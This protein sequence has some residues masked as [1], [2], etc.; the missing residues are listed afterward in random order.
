M[1]IQLHDTGVPVNHIFVM[2]TL[3]ISRG[4]HNKMGES[5][6]FQSFYI[7]YICL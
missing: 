6:Q 5:S 7:H 1:G 3:A 2:R 4:F